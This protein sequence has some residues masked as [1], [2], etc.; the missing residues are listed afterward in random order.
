MR[1]QPHGSTFNF[2]APLF[3]HQVN[4]WMRRVRVNLS[5]VSIFQTAHVTC[6]LYGCNLET[7]AYAKEG[8]VVLP[9][10]LCCSHFA[11]R[12]AGSKTVWNKNAVVVF[13]VTDA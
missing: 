12:A 6:K 10:K 9:C 5:A 11:F 13:E 7:V 3:R 8:D 2:Y 1:A 4:N